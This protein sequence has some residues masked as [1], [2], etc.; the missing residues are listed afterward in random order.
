MM[1]TVPKWLRMFYPSLEWKVQGDAEN[2]YLTFDDGPHPEITPKV[3]DLLDQFNAKATFFCVADNVRKYP[4]IYRQ[5][6]ERG[7]RVG[8][9]SYHHLNGW[10]TKNKIYFDDVEQAAG[11]IKS[12]LFRPP[13]GKLSPHQI[14]VLKKQYRIVMW[15]V[16]TYDFRRTITPEVCL[17]NAL[18]GLDPGSIIVFHD[19]E[20]SARNMFY[21]LPEYLKKCKERNLKISSL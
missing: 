21:A 10:K 4:D 11:L 14:S 18:L 13:Y 16:L 7:H 9:H 1:V 5:I 6:I 8:N 12:N 15:S 17:Q 20:K 3:L 19:S 2:V